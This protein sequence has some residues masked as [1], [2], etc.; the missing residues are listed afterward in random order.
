VGSVNVTRAPD[1]AAT[2]PEAEAQA[3]SGSPAPRRILF[4]T[5]TYE[6]GG[7]EKHLLDLICRLQQP[8]LKILLLCLGMDP[9]SQRL[10]ARPKVNVMARPAPRSLLGWVRLLQPLRADIVVFVHGWLWSFHWMASIGAWLARV[11]KR[12]SIQHLI[13]PRDPN[14]SII[15]KLVQKLVG[16][17]NLKISA[18]LFHRTIAVSEAVR[19]ELIADFGFPSGRVVTI[20]N[21]VSLPGVTARSSEDTVIRAKWGLGRNDFLFLCTARLSPQK[22]IEILLQALA[23]CRQAGLRFSCVIVGDGPLKERL[24]AQAKELGLTGVVFFEG[25]QEDIRPY[26]HASSAFILTSHREGLPLAILEALAAGLPCLV[27]DVGG[28]A[29]A[30]SHGVEGL[31]IPAGSVDRAV[32]AISYLV[33]HPDRC[34][35][36]SS[37]ARQR[38]CESFDIEKQMAAIQQILLA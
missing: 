23:R 8:D 31:L 38:A 11:P 19:N 20:R 32:D 14:R 36:M 21:G 15:Q 24:M 35:E 22:G 5:R 17:L 30:V 7:A 26:L 1:T 6:Y 10:A 18:S 2:R 12:Y 9:Y 25:Y 33:A 13:I 28:N 34:Q 4:V 29:E 27:T 16:P 3:V 37:K